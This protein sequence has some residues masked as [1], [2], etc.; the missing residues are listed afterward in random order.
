MMFKDKC[1]VVVKNSGKIMREHDD[2]IFLPFGSEYSLAFK[3]LESRTA[4]AKVEIDGRDV[5]NGSR[6]IIYP[7]IECS[8]ER[9]LGVDLNNGNRFKFIKKTKEISEFRGDRIDD[10][11]IRIEFWFEEKPV[12]WKFI[13]FKNNNIAGST[14]YKTPGVPYRL[15]DNSFQRVGRG[16]TGTT[17][18]R[19]FG[20][21]VNYSSIVDDG[22]TVKG[23]KSSQS[24]R[25]DSI[26]TLES[27]SHVVVLKLN[28]Y[29]EKNTVI[30]KPIT[31]KTRIQCE[32]CGRKWKSNLK[33]CPNCGT[34]LL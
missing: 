8:L 7:D 24:F 15:T 5:L 23:S 6:L 3:N 10:G 20:S 32:T 28:G 11:L 19:S 33:Y 34:Y 21:T 2:Q 27:D 1:I 25:Y 12:E 22:I 14:P 18:T 29:S 26:R 9:F 13:E 17:T 4:V 31:V 30:E 16:I